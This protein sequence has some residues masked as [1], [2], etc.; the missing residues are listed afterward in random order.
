MTRNQQRVNRVSI[1]LN[2]VTPIDGDSQIACRDTRM[3]DA[4]ELTL[5]DIDSLPPTL[6]LIAAAKILGIGRTRA[7]IL[8]RDGVFPCPV[9]R[10]GHVYRVSTIQLLQLLGAR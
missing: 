7:Y 8:A 1:E 3:S 6:S 5:A 9:L 2:R 4:G 10:F